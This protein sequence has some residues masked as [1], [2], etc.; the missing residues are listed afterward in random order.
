MNT[1]TISK[2][3]H[4]ALMAVALAASN[5]RHPALFDMD[6]YGKRRIEQELDRLGEIHSF[7]A[8]KDP[9]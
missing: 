4:S 5:I 7:F 1:V 6:G 2:A 3:E 9:K 8:K